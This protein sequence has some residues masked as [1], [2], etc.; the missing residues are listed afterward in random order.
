MGALGVTHARGRCP[1]C[2]R[3]LAGR[4]EGIE[5]LAA[6]RRWVILPAHVREPGI[7][8][9][10]RVECLSRGTRRVVPRIPDAELAAG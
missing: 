7:K 2:G 4:A 3:V 9:P 1:D 6:D 10:R 8:P 5:R